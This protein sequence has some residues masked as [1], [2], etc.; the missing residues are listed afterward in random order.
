MGCH[1]SM[2]TDHTIRPRSNTGRSRFPH[3]KWWEFETI[4]NRL[5]TASRVDFTQ[6]KH[7]TIRARLGR[8]LVAQHLRTAREYLAHIDSHPKI[9]DLSVVRLGRSPVT[10]T[11]RPLGKTAGSS[12]RRFTLFEPSR[13]SLHYIPI[14]RVLDYSRQQ[15]TI[16]PNA[17]VEAGDSLGFG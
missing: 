3:G 15:K 12:S 5:E 11:A 7:S 17:I 16:Q 2:S 13:H 8:R 4:P 1:G 9:H 14:C 6:D 10:Y